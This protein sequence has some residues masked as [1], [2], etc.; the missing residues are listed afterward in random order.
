[1]S[2][3]KEI[4]SNKYV[5][6][7]PPADNNYKNIVT[8]EPGGYYVSCEP[9]IL[10]TVLGSCIAVCVYDCQKFIAGMNHFIL[11]QSGT[12]SDGYTDSAARYGDWAMEE[13]INSMLKKGCLKNNLVFKAFGGARMFQNQTN[14]GKRNIEFIEKFLK[15]EAYSLSAHDFGG[16]VGRKVNFYTDTG[17]VKIKRLTDDT[18]NEL[19]NKERDYVDKVNHYEDDSDGGVELFD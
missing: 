4:Y 10:T 19:L 7:S 15:D 11:P 8:I 16:S 17:T 18:K 5:R 1:L 12:T 14:I 6:T 2:T 3:R 9:N 13:L